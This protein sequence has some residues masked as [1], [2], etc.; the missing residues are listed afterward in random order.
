MPLRPY[1]CCFHIYCSL[2]LWGFS[3]HIAI[4]EAHSAACLQLCVLGVTE[5]FTTQSPAQQAGSLPHCSVGTERM[6]L[7]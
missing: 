6:Q 4:P 2:G 5:G 1:P 7:S 3:Q